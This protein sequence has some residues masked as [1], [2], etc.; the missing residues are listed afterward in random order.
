L[1]PIFNVN[2]F[3]GEPKSLEELKGCPSEGIFIKIDSTFLEMLLKRCKSEQTT[4]HAALVA[5]LVQVSP[6]IVPKSFVNR[7]ANAVD[8]RNLSKKIPIDKRQVG[9]W[10]AGVE[11]DFIPPFPEF[12]QL[13]RYVRQQVVKRIPHAVEVIGVMDYIAKYKWDQF[14]DRQRSIT[15]NGKSSTFGISNLGVWDVPKNYGSVKLSGCIF[16]QGNSAVGPLIQLSMVTF[17]GKLWI[18]VTY[19]STILSKQQ[20][21]LFVDQLLNRLKSAVQ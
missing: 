21:Q 15:V 8:I 14:W 7:V 16:S 5:A 1:V 20:I 18:S 4:L 11:I 6:H 10:V 17:D 19:P 13:A 3:A 9:V 2:Y 12:W